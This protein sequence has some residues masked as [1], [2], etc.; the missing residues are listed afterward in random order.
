MCRGSGRLEG[1]ERI[2]HIPVVDLP[3]GGGGRGM[4]W[5]NS[6]LY[7]RVGF[8][9]VLFG[10]EFPFFVEGMYEEKFVWG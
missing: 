7:K 9:R 6:Q 1:G 10:N 5:V 8:I 2:L 4:G 3:S